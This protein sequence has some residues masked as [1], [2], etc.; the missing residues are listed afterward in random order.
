MSHLP[1]FMRREFENGPVVHETENLRAHLTVPANAHGRLAL[2]RVFRD[3][4]L[5]TPLG[6]RPTGVAVQQ[7][8]L[9]VQTNRV[10]N[11]RRVFVTERTFLTA[12]PISNGLKVCLFDIFPRISSEAKTGKRSRSPSPVEAESRADTTRGV[13]GTGRSN[14]LNTVFYENNVPRAR[15]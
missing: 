2:E 11:M 13:T 9:D 4:A 1:R 6:E 12:V 8:L 10:Q 15:I 14:A 5:Q 3:V 7:F